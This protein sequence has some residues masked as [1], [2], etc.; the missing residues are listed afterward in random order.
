MNC[1]LCNFSREVNWN[2]DHCV[3]I[4]APVAQYWFFSNLISFILNRVQ[5]ILLTVMQIIHF[6]LLFSSKLDLNRC[7]LHS[8]RVK[9]L[10]LSISSSP[11]MFC[12]KASHLNF[13]AKMSLII[14]FHRVLRG[15]HYLILHL[16]KDSNNNFANPYITIK[17]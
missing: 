10:F 5:I 7:F 6:L 12:F 4:L 11:V 3:L 13:I 15:K 17:N 2:T 14:Y 9:S 16:W 1:I 8:R